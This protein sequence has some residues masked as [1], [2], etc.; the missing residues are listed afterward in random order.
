LYV[1]ESI[2]ILVQ[3]FIRSFIWC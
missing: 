2:V 1:R 3:L